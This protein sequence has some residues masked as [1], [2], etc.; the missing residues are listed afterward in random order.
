MGPIGPFSDSGASAAK[1]PSTLFVG[2]TNN[3]RSDIADRRNWPLIRTVELLEC[4]RQ[5]G[6]GDPVVVEESRDLG[7]IEGVQSGRRQ[8]PP[9]SGPGAADDGLLEP[10]GRIV[11]QD[12]ADRLARHFERM[13]GVAGDVAQ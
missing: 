4:P 3:E 9:V 5:I 12:M 2:S 10:S 7:R 13:D 8:L 1:P 11:I 6:G